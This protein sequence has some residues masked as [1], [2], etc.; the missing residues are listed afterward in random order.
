MTPVTPIVP[1]RNEPRA[2]AWGQRGGISRVLGSGE[3]DAVEAELWLGSHPGSPSRCVAAPWESLLDWE[4]STGQELPYLLKVLAAAEPLS[5]QAHPSAERARRG[6]DAEEARGVPRD[7]P[8]RS[9]KDPQAKPELV[10]AVE[11]GFEALCGFAPLARTRA[12]V[13]TLR[14]LAD[15]PA[16]YERWLELLDGDDGLHCS[17]AW[18]LS[19]DPVAAAL[20][21]DLGATAARDAERF[22][23]V[24][25]LEERHPGDPG[26]AV[27]VMLNH[28]VLDEGESL[29][30]PAGNIHAYLSGVAME[31]MGPSDNVLRGGLTGK[32]VDV[33]ELLAVLD[34]A[35][36]EPPRLVPEP[37]GDHVL[38]YRP[39]SVPSGADVPFELRT[40]AGD[41]VVETASPAVALVVDGGFELEVDGEGVSLG[42]GDAVFVPEPAALRLTGAGRLYLASAH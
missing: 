9:Y 12:E 37:E 28:V 7:A 11:D 40:I 23:V 10:V 41:A 34:F 42:R 16:P 21:A 29:W 31:L 14:A 4:R 5:L 32:H 36:C 33:R 30:L 8:H 27:A 25:R 20:A 6:F 15:D 39:A 26:V 19:D 3:S 17:V 18:L 13:D 24:G 22:E 38:V 2:Y 35:D 1:I